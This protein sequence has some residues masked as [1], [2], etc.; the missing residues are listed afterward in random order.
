MLVAGL[1]LLVTNED[2]VTFVTH[3]SLNNTLFEV[4]AVRS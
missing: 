3:H 4:K 1:V 2:F